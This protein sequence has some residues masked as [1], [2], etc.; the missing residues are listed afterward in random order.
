MDLNQ[1]TLVLFEQERAQNAFIPPQ[2]S[3]SFYTVGS[4]II[5][6]YC[7]NDSLIDYEFHVKVR[8][9]AIYVGDGEFTIGDHYSTFIVN[10]SESLINNGV[11]NVSG[12]LDVHGTLTLQTGSTLNISGGIITM[13]PSSVLIIEEGAMIINNGSLN[14]YGALR[15]DVSL[16]ND[17]LHMENVYIDSAADFIATNVD[18]GNREISLTDYEAIL[19]DIIISPN[20][21]GEYTFPYGKVGYVWKAGTW[22][23]H[24]QVIQLNV[25]RGDAVFGDFKIAVIGVQ[26]SIIPNRQVVRNVHVKT[27]GILH[28]ADHYDDFTYLYPELYIGVSI[29][30]NITPGSCIVDGAIVVDGSTAMITLDRKSTLTINEGGI[31]YLQNDGSM[32]ST[33]NDG[34]TV[35]FING[36]LVLDTINQITTFEP[37]NIEFGD[38]GKIIILNK[39]TDDHHV[40]FST[41]NGVHDTDLYRILEPHLQHVE[42]RIPTNCGIR[43]DEYFPY[44]STMMTDWYAGM[45]IEK[46]IHDKLII[47][48]DGAFMELDHSIIPWATTASSLLHAA[49]LFKSSKSYDAEKLQEVIE[50]LIYA[51]CGNITFRFIE[52]E[53]YAD[54][55]LVLNEINMNSI[56]NSTSSNEYILNTDASGELFMKHNISDASSANIIDESA[57]MVHLSNG[58][59]IFTLT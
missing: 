9:G 12:A 14:I 53:D 7:A 19:Q 24:S 38:N 41:P 20:T 50:H 3:N 10:K 5:D 8:N 28:V 13:H 31:V 27:G 18:L 40:L 36:T 46:A 42:Y 23:D 44:Y 48:D 59:T 26:Q 57:T 58:D 37:S 25:I 32:R 21:Q 56:T 11:L 4:G 29:G 34:E 35:L 55:T 17:F 30:N 6:L 16:A 1:S 47:W 33:N 15:V 43:I 54:V 2:E 22:S 39:Y 49:R 52:G 45:R 51:G